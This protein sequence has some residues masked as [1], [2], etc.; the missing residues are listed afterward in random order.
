MMIVVYSLMGAYNQM[1]KP[2]VKRP[3]FRPKREREASYC[4]VCESKL[5]VIGAFGKLYYKCS[6]CNFEEG[7]I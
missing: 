5:N 7:D 3:K 1:N 4:P 2:K 6:F